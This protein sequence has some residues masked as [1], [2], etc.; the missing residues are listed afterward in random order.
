MQ[1]LS[2]RA[3]LQ[4]CR[5]HTCGV[6]YDGAVALVELAVQRLAARPVC[7]LSLTGCALGLAPGAPLPGSAQL[8]QAVLPR[9]RGLE[10]GGGSLLLFTALLDQCSGLEQLTLT[11]PDSF[12]DGSVSALC[13]HLG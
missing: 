13:S 12:S 1:L 4:L 6:G 11:V 10:L 2:C 5:L 3:R 9:L 7:H 8:A